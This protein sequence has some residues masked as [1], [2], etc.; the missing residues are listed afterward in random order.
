MT[1]KPTHE[2][3]EQ[4]VKVLEKESFEQKRNA[5]DLKDQKRRL[6]SLIEYSSLAI[7]TLDEGQNI[8]SCNRDFEKLFYFNESEMVGRNLDEL[9]A[10]QEYIE[11][12]LLY[13][14]ETRKGKA[15]HGSGKRQRKDGAYIDVEFIGVPIII[16][17]KLIGAYGI[18]QDISERKR[19]EEALKI[20]GQRLTQIINFLPDATF[21]IDSDGKVIAWN[22][23]IE[24]MTGVKAEDMLGKG[25]YEY[26]IPFYGNRRPVLIDLVGKWNEEV[27]QKYQ[28]VK[29]E[30]DF[31]V[32]ETY[33]P[34]VKPD[35][36]LWNKASCL[37][38]SNGEVIGAI[39]SIRDITESKRTEEALRES[40]EK[41]RN[42]L[43]SIEDGYFEVD[44]A[45]NFT[46]FNDSLR[47]IL[48]YS[49]DELMGM[50]NR[51]YV[52]EENAKKLYQTFNKVYSTGKAD[53]GFDLEIIRKDGSKRYVEASVSLR[54]DPEGQPTGFRGIVRDVTERK[55]AEEA[56]RREEEKFR[57]L[58]EKSPLGVS[59]IGE[60]GH[61]EYLNPKFIKM[62]GYTL[63]DIP[64]GR[65]WFI[66]AYPD[67]RY[68]H[69]VISTWIDDLEKCKTRESRPRSFK[70]S[71]KDGSEK[72]VYFW[73]VTM[74]T[75]E[76]FV[77][78]EDITER[79]RLEVQL[80][81]AQKMEA[82]GTLAG[83]VAHDLNNI[84]SG[85][86]SYP[87]LL[88]MDLPEDSPLRKP[89]LTIKKSGERAA[90]IVQD[91]LTL[92]RRGVSVSEVVNLNNIISEQLTSLEY[93]KLKSFH[94]DVQVET[95]F[96]K[97]LLNIKGST[98]HL[99]KTVMNLI[100]NAAE[101]MPDGG[102][103]FIS[104]ENR[105][106]DR[107]ITGYDHVEEGDYVTVT[108]FDTGIGISEED[109]KKIFEPFYTKKVMG[110]SGTGLGM[111]VVWGTVKDHKGYINVESS[112]GQ[113]TTFTLYF[114]V[115]REEIVS[116]ISVL[117]IEEYMGKGEL[118][119]V[120]DDVEE[121]C[122]IASRILNKLGYSAISVLSGEE[123]VDYMKDNSADL[124]VLDMIMDPGIDGLETYKRIL[125]LHP[126]QKAIIASGFSETE[127]VKEAQR[128]G[129]GKYI[130]K[131][132]ALEKIGLA[133]KEELGK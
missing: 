114:P 60:D 61:Y 30:E 85:I 117:H 25:N 70:V 133:V 103:I 50:S 118:I 32:S 67:S 29:K 21:A 92:A 56:L 51:Q 79:I 86:V 96:E 84:L 82:I 68:R 9:I 129:A 14:K 58:V 26:A 20:S 127:R 23:A 98:A 91:L 83:G 28:Y 76:Q 80:Q 33:D 31:L 124:L 88:L 72:E 109:I 122:E 16:D 115:T 89:I 53:K 47:N 93:E 52:D 12:A 99:S 63:E 101:A 39:E 49:K 90:I 54:K 66:K 94:P 65:D 104:T 18:Y 11:D 57:I 126:G 121:Q 19:A 69:E 116:D 15:I 73:P 132:Y 110:R 128:L 78:H 43:E 6:E 45:G 46:F 34:L 71:C 7:V 77:V 112:E 42:I 22:L 111:A 37:Y 1:K 5:E 13:T 100:S 106:I 59:L 108:I 64:A 2:E 24:K 62:F 75:G 102:N 105:Y 48:G 123:A 95:H 38:D 131:P 35:G 87:E 81:Q 4:R 8:I 10:G 130:K 113:G 125:E 3:L 97:D 120:V 17:G 107:P 119:L 36:F 41:Y 74:E 55:L 40:E 27:K 44:N